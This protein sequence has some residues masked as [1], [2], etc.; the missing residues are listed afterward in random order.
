MGMTIAE[1]IIAAA[2]GVEDKQIVSVKVGKEGERSV[3][4]GDVVVRVSPKY[5]A[6][7]HIDTD[8]AN[9]AGIS[10]EVEGEIIR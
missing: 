1:K 9:A 3:I 5:A 8:E 10:G 2:A 7:M 6:A 4:F